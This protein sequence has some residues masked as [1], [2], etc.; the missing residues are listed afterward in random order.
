MN[1]ARNAEAPEDPASQGLIEGWAQSFKFCPQRV[2]GQSILPR[3]LYSGSVERERWSSRYNP[4]PCCCGISSHRIQ[5]H[6]PWGSDQPLQIL[7]VPPITALEP[8]AGCPSVSTC[9]GTQLC[10]LLALCSVTW[11]ELQQHSLSPSRPAEP[12]HLLRC[13]S[14]EV[15]TL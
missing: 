5:Y 7:Y 11:H 10:L 2:L 14:G 13:N 15:S 3:S 6:F 4:F 1:S 12:A 8:L 9:T